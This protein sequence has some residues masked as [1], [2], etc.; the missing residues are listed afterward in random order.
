MSATYLSAANASRWTCCCLSVFNWTTPGAPDGLADLGASQTCITHTDNTIR[1][2]YTY[3]P[4][5]AQ[6]RI[7]AGEKVPLVLD[8]HGYTSWYTDGILK[9]SL[10]G[11]EGSKN[12]YCSTAIVRTIL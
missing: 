2:W 12:L 5:A 9:L 4:P 6:T 8:L 7:E 1:C 3:I 10:T 11:C